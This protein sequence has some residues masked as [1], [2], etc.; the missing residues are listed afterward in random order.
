MRHI[1]RTTTKKTRR[2]LC[3][4]LAALILVAAPLPAF[5]DTTPSGPTNPA[6]STVAPSESA[7]SG[8]DGTNSTPTSTPVVT[9]PVLTLSAT[10][11]S[12]VPLT[13]PAAQTSEAP[14]AATTSTAPTGS[15]STYTGQ[16]Q[17]T[18]TATSGS[19]TVS[20]NKKA[21]SA[22][23]GDAQSNATVV[24]VANSNTNFGT[25]NNFTYYTHD[26][27]GDQNSD[28]TIDP[29]A[30]LQGGATGSTDTSDFQTAVSLTDILNNISLS[31]KSGDAIVS[32]NNK[33]GDATS[34]DASA[35]ANVLNIVGSAISA[36]N[37]FLGIVNIYGNLKGNIL[38]PASFVDSLIDGSNTTASNL[39]NSD[40]TIENNINA[41]AHSGDA[42]VSGNKKAGDATSGNATTSL[43]VYNLTG[44][45]VVAKNSLLVFVNVLGKWVGMIV[46]APGSNSAEFG[47][48]I[49]TDAS[50]DS[51]ATTGNSTTHI[52]NNI[53]V[54]ANSGDA[55]VSGNK[56]A[57]DAT[58]GNASA[59]VSLVNI[60]NSN[61][62][63]GDWF[64]ALFINVLGSW[65]GDFDIKDDAPTASTGTDPGD[66]TTTESAVQDVRIFRFDSEAPVTAIQD[67]SG[68]QSQSNDDSN[69]QNVA[70]T[71]STDDTPTGSVLGANTTTGN[72]SQD[73]GQATHSISID[74][75][76]LVA[77]VG[78]LTLLIALGSLAVRRRFV[79]A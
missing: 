32:D 77:I 31:A 2:I 41:T 56:K 40:T 48:D 79:T 45:E 78:A 64:G 17:V 67:D 23:S 74:L 20:D 14:T 60:T 50:A 34:G 22:T 70:F 72:N 15:S 12:P 26:I 63:L 4:F 71:A 46:Q 52:T 7:A 10:P 65:I 58:S 37:S 47:K 18:S 21:G 6:A 57:G 53:S 43:T 33:A 29:S 61:F 55:T 3:G 76:A 35:L 1:L 49:S 59:G 28:L 44:Q 66:Q 8:S 11:P 16:N 54:D 9:A 25:G 27:T 62:K 38:V 68:D 5:A 30:F 24:N 69:Y 51:P 39:G 36:Q 73:A 19:A 42:T 13:L 75:V